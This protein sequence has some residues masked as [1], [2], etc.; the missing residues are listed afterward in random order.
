MYLK[1]FVLIAIQSAESDKAPLQEVLFRWIKDNGGHVNDKLG[2]YIDPER[3]GLYA[4]D[5]LKRGEHLARISDKTR[6]LS[7]DE[8][9]VVTQFRDEIIKNETSFFHPFISILEENDADPVLY[10]NDQELLILQHSYP[11]NWKQ[12]LNVYATQCL[13]NTDNPIDLKALS[14]FL[15]YAQYDLEHA[16]FSITPLLHKI[17]APHIPT[18]PTN[19]EIVKEWLLDESTGALMHILDI[20]ALQ[21]IHKDEELI[22]NEFTREL[23]ETFRDFGVVLSYPHFIN[24]IG[25]DEKLY[26]F[27]INVD[28]KRIFEIDVNPLENDYQQDLIAIAD[29]VRNELLMFVDSNGLLESKDYLLT[30][31]L[32]MRRHHHNME[33]NRISKGNEFR[34]AYISDLCA[35]ARVL[36]PS[37]KGPS[38]CRRK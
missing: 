8:C 20:Y 24:I 1:L 18:L 7:G 11:Y 29:E 2:L 19:V 31:I 28:E 15:R 13:I 36:P 17:A 38:A 6:I 3:N 10:W 30:K 32:Q 5:N 35:I 21:D 34:Q 16:L 33:L 37:E 22:I 27:W 14:L 25:G 26:T 9:S 4:N 23:S 12:I